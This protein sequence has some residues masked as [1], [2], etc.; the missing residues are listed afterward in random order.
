MPRVTSY[1][2]PTTDLQG[3]NSY[4]VFRRLGWKTARE[5]NKYL[6]IGNVQTRSDLTVDEIEKRIA[7]EERLTSECVLNGIL[8]WNW[9]DENGTPIPIPTKME[10]LDALTADEVTF[11]IMHA[12]GASRQQELKE[13][14][15]KN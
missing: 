3:E 10:D 9:Q 14:D 1:R 7:E 12:T 2:V 11:L 8:E 13:A 4:V 15:A 5:V 6:V